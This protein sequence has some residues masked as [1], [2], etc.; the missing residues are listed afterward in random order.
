MMETVPSRRIW[1]SVGSMMGAAAGFGQ[2]GSMMGNGE[3]T[4]ATK[5]S[6]YVKSL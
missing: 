3:F 6:S 5:S 1:Q 4:G 2:S